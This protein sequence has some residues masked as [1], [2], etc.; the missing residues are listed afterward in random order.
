MILFFRNECFRVLVLQTEG[1]FPEDRLEALSWLFNGA[2]LTDPGD[3]LLKGRFRP[4]AQMITLSTVAVKFV[5][6]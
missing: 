5:R 3:P 1:A 2:V 4:E 6:T